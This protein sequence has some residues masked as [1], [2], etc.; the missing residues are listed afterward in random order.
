MIPKASQLQG[1]NVSDAYIIVDQHTP[2]I[3]RISCRTKSEKAYLTLAVGGTKLC[4]ALNTMTYRLNN[5]SRDVAV[6][7]LRLQTMSTSF[8]K[9]IAYSYRDRASLTISSGVFL[10]GLRLRTGR[11][12]HCVA[13]GQPVAKILLAC[14]IY[15]HRHY[16]TDLAENSSGGMKSERDIFRPGERILLCRNVARALDRTRN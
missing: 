15:K 3:L 1:N 5:R 4:T 10:R 6:R 9:V 13:V 16:T 2:V 7:G 8:V 12:N 14:S 11:C